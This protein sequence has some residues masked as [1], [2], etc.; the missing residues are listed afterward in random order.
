MTHK[1]LVEKLQSDIGIIS[2]MKNV[3]PNDTGFK[4]H[5]TTLE[6]TAIEVSNSGFTMIGE[7]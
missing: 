2:N 5:H 1:E 6:G 7:K 3:N 4:M